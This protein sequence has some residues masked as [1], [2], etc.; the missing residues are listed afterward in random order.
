MVRLF[1]FSAFNLKTKHGN[2]PCKLIRLLTHTQAMAQWHS[3]ISFDRYHKKAISDY[4]ARSP[5]RKTFKLQ[6]ASFELFISEIENMHRVSIELYKHE[7]KFGRTRNAVGTRAAG[8][9][10]HS[11][12]VFSQTFTS[13][14]RET[15]EWHS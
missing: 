13:A 6:K 10:F 12:F 3:A 2:P 5:L 9:C 11:F 15:H 8:E 4:C 1:F 7:W 14:T